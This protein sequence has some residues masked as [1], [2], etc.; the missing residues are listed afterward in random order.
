MNRDE[1]RAFVERFFR[2]THAGL[3]G[4]PLYPFEIQGEP[5]VKD[6]T[7]PETGWREYSFQYGTVL[8]Q[9]MTGRILGSW[10]QEPAGSNSPTRYGLPRKLTDAD[11]IVLTQRYYSASGYPEKVSVFSIQD[12]QGNNDN[13]VQVDYVPAHRGVPF[14][15]SFGGYMWLGRDDGRLMSFSAPTGHAPWITTLPKPPADLVPRQQPDAARLAAFQTVLRAWGGLLEESSEMSVHL[16]IWRPGEP[17]RG[18][19]RWLTPEEDKA[20]LANQGRLVYAVQV[21]DLTGGVYPGSKTPGKFYNVYVDAG[22]GRVLQIDRFPEIGGGGGGAP[23]PARM[24]WPNGA[25]MWRA[26]S[27]KGG[28]S[29]PV[30]GA[31]RTVGQAD[32]SPG[33]EIFLSDGRRAIRAA[34]DVK[35]GLLGIRKP[36]GSEYW[37]ARPT[38]ALLTAVAH[39]AAGKHRSSGTRTGSPEATTTKMH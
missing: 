26:S 14:D 6:G 23:V 5:V 28:W 3:G 24:A 33:A 19:Y 29:K 11:A 17:R 22:S 35:R 25:S 32:F 16:S 20:A 36:T 34:F 31:L 1:E 9:P 30:S 8:T 4:V 15:R 21:V 38:A 10:I 7:N 13:S 39:A 12:F 37:V 18:R 2:L 27:D